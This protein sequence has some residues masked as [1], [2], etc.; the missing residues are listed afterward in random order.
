MGPAPLPPVRSV[1]YGSHP[2]QVASL[3]LPSGGDGSWPCVVLLHGG[4]WRSGWDRTLMTPLANDLAGRGLA[5]WN[6]EFRGTGADGGG[7]PTTLL[8]VAAAVDHLAE[9]EAVDVRRVATCGHSAGGHLAL[10]AAARHRLPEGSALGSPAVRP[11]AAVSLAGVP[12]LAQAASDRLGSG[13]VQALLEAEPDEEPDRYALTSPAALV[14]LR[15]R[16]LLVHGDRDE[17]VPDAQSGSFAER[18]ASE[19]DD[20][21]LRLLP[22]VDHFQVIDAGHPAWRGT[23]DWLVDALVGAA[24]PARGS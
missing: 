22:R 7:W 16:L 1:R 10:W 3:H 21:E 8:D 4:F 12:D 23:A 11:T 14:P 18:A 6:V 20:V 2:S 9:L 17:I 13:A 19:G 15:A 5:A 24:T